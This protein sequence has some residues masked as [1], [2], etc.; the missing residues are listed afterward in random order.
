MSDSYMQDDWPKMP[1]DS[2]FDG[3]NLLTLVRKGQSPF[4]GAWDVNLLI[5]EVEENLH[6]QVIEI[7]T[8][9]DGANFYVRIV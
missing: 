2:D 9:Y 3:K 1:D 8:V 6:S 4:D 5:Q 7:P